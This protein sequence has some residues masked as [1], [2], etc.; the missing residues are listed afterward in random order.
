MTPLSQEEPDA[1]RVVLLDNGIKPG[2]V[3]LGDS[4]STL[5]K[6]QQQLTETGRKELASNIRDNI[7][8]GT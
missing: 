1:L 3:S 4:Q 2:E 6:V 7:N 5:E 8:K